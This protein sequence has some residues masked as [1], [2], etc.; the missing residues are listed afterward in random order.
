[1][2]DQDDA[3]WE[4]YSERETDG[5]YSWSYGGTTVTYGDNSWQYHEP[6]TF[7]PKRLSERFY[8]EL[9]PDHVNQLLAN[10][11]AAQRKGAVREHL[12]QAAHV[13]YMRRE[14]SDA[15]R[16]LAALLTQQCIDM[17]PERCR[18]M[19]FEWRAKLLLERG[20]GDDAIQLLTSRLEGCRDER[21]RKRLLKA[22]RAAER[23]R[24]LLK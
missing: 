9:A 16:A 10:W 12:E 2:R 3:A 18:P 1:L 20:Q 19:M 24:K 11:T 13:A 22:M 8:N 15:T 6:D 23:K 4:R 17:Y 21:E 5:E 14:H 7:R